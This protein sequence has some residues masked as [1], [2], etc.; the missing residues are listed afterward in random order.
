[1]YSTLPPEEKNPFD[2]KNNFHLFYCIG[3]IVRV[4]LQRRRRPQ[5][6]PTVILHRQLEYIEFCGLVGF[7]LRLDSLLERVNGVLD[8]RDLEDG[9]A[10]LNPVP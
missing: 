2:I 10:I 9:I 8:W 5:H 4:A 1:M 6:R 7:P 3:S